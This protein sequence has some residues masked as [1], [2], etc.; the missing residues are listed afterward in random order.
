MPDFTQWPLTQLPT[1]K[2]MKAENHP[3]YQQIIYN[4]TWDRY[5][6]QGRWEML[7]GLIDDDPIYMKKAYAELAAS[8]NNWQTI[9]DGNEAREMTIEIAKMY[10]I[11]KPFITSEEDALYRGWL[12][13][14][15]DKIIGKT[16]RGTRF[17][18]S[19]Q[20][21]GT[22]FGLCM[23]DKVLGTKYL[24]GNVLN[25][26][27]GETLP[28]GGL[29]ATGA[30]YRTMRNAVHRF[31]TVLAKDGI[32]IE[33]QGGYNEGTTQLMYMGAYWA[34]I[35]HF[36]EVKEFMKAHAKYLMHFLTPDLKEMFQEGD[37]EHPHE[38]HYFLFYAL[39][40]LLAF[41]GG[42]CDD[43]DIAAMVRQFEEDLYDTNAYVRHPLI[44]R[45]Y[46]FYDP[47]GEKK[48]WKEWAGDSLVVRGQ[49]HAFWQSGNKATH[50][51]F[52]SNM[53]VDHSQAYAFGDMM[54]YK[55]G[56]FPI[57][58]PICY[59]PDPLYANTVLVGA[60]IGPGYEGGGL[61]GSAFVKDKIA[62]ASGGWAGMNQ[63]I[64]N[65]GYGEFP[66]FNH[67][68]FRYVFDL[69]DGPELVQVVI[70]A[71]H[72]EDPKDQV[73]D[74]QWGHF[75]WEE[76]YR[77]STWRDMINAVPEGKLWVW[78][79]ATKPLITGNTITWDA[80][81][82]E[83]VFPANAKIVAYDEKTTVLGGYISDEEK[84]WQTRTTQAEKKVY[85]VVAHGITDSP[86]A[87]FEK[88]EVGDL[89]GVTVKRPGKS[90]VTVLVSNKI[91]PKLETD[92]YTVGE[93]IRPGW[94][95]GAERTYIKL[96][97]TKF[98][99]VVGARLVNS[100]PTTLPIDGDVYIADLASAPKSLARVTGGGAPTPVPVPVPIPDP[101]PVDPP[102]TPDPVPNPPPVPVPPPV[103][104][105]AGDDTSVTVNTIQFAPVISNSTLTTVFTWTQE[106]GPVAY[107]EDIH[108][109]NTKVVFSSSGVYKFW[110]TAGVMSGTAPRDYIT[111]TVAFP[112]PVPVPD[113]TPVP[114]LPCLASDLKS[115]LDDIKTLLDK[116]FK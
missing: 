35:E 24:E 67:G 18:D 37:N 3:W 48:P 9:Y 33:A 75:T 82:I 97:T 43:P 44:A 79:Q 53:E 39:G 95:T 84:K 71:V 114:P 13:A 38:M 63:F 60:A 77:Y 73:L 46:Y 5:A 108:N 116:H 45:Y 103:K 90:P 21:L 51:H 19:D 26:D 70:D 115:T 93:E 109:P 29:T 91:G 11:L 27:T 72:A 42:L 34:G 7:R 80:M 20:C 25:P 30:N 101:P 55:D 59:Q 87:K 40:D 92:Y 1:W 99:T 110:L 15:A 8:L 54:V 86:T 106:T 78:H 10:E 111:I 104:I 68:T 56:T 107:I 28:V 65:G 61:V 85:Q 74:N 12:I 96:N 89:I 69:I 36:P 14:V 83:Q 16:G 23:I 94:A 64:Y 52:P 57:Y 58:R 6:D 62:F 100:V 47:Y 76:I 113:P 105:Y 88:I 49:G 112:V 17:G 32:W 98:E 4:T 81:R 102:P 41:I 2:K 22:F 50:V 31:V 66:T